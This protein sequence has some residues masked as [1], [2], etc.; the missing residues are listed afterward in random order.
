MATRGSVKPA[1]LI[2]MRINAVRCTTVWLRGSM[3]R[4][5]ADFVLPPQI[6]GR[7]HAFGLTACDVHMQMRS[8]SGGGSGRA[9]M[10]REEGNTVKRAAMLG[11]GV[12]LLCSGCTAQQAWRPTVDTYGSSRAQF[13]SRDTEEC[14]NL[15]LQASGTSAQAGARGAVTGG[16]VGAAAGAAI[17]SAFGSAGRGA[18]VG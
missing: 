3:R 5:S 11:V 1:T 16:L 2:G 18:V 4:P 17:G 14:R 13:V 10:H 8:S 9:T 15:A 12:V 7:I 6:T